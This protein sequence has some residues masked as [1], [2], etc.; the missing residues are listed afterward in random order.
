MTMGIDAAVAIAVS[1][2]GD[3][4]GANWESG[5]AVAAGIGDAIVGAAD[6]FASTGSG[7]GVAL[8]VTTGTLAAGSEFAGTGA[9]N[10]F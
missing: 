5:K 9:V 3:T 6:G 2:V 1:A 7:D 4:G 10:V 8:A